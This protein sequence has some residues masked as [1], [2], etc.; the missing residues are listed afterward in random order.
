MAV[1]YFQDRKNLKITTINI[2]MIVALIIIYDN[3][4]FI[5]FSS[6]DQVT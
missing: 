5:I 1:F 6:C 4:Y 2:R 3:S